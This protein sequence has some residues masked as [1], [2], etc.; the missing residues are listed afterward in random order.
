MIFLY[1]AAGNDSAAD[2]LAGGTLGFLLALA[3]YGLLVRG[4]RWFSWRLFFRLT[5]V[6]LLL[7]SGALLVDGTDKLIGL[8][9]LP[10]LADPLWDASGLIYDG[11]R[12]GGLL[13]AFTGWR[14]MPTGMSYLALAAWWTLALVWVLRARPAGGKG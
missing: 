13:A 2:L 9:A 5:E 3:A 8:E 6:M 14:N 4:A 12:A 11:G 1:G 7:L 10:T